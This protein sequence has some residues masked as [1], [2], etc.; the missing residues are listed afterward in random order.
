MDLLWRRIGGV[1]LL[2]RVQPDIDCLLVRINIKLFPKRL[3]IFG[4]NLELDRALRNRRKVR[5][6]LLIRVHFPMRLPAPAEFRDL[7]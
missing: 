2:W 5:Q 4:H 1:L 6:S 3:M 7:V